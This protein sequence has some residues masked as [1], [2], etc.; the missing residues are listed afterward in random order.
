MRCK[1]AFPQLPAGKAPED[2]Y[3]ALNKVKFDNAIRVESDELTYPL[4][5]IIRYE[6]SLLATPNARRRKYVKPFKL[7]LELALVNGDISV[8]ELPGMWREKMKSYLG[9]EPSNDAQGVLQDIHWSAGLIGYFPTYSLGAMMAVQLFE[10]AK[11]SI[12]N[13]EAEI[14]AGNFKGLREWLKEKVHSKGSLYASADE[15]MISATGEPLRPSVFLAYLKQKYSS[16]YK[17]GL[18]PPVK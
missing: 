15:L 14:A 7:Q 1:A 3:L 2:L 9:V 5:I 16:I 11:K 4:H 13:L 10:A 12:P 8:A 17:L 6:V 18:P